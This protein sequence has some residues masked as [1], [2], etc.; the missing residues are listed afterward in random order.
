MEEM[1]T[2]YPKYDNY[3]EQDLHDEYNILV[4]KRWKILINYKPE[5]DEYNDCLIEEV[6]KRM[7][8][9]DRLLENKYSETTFTD[10]N[11]GK[12]VTI[13]R[14]GDP[15]TSVLAPELDLIVELPENEKMFAVEDFIRRKHDE[16]FRFDTLCNDKATELIQNIDKTNINITFKPLT[17]R[18]ECGNPQIVLKRDTKGVL[19]YRKQKQQKNLLNK[20]RNW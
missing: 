13:Q 2:M 10:N 12:T 18:N 14:K 1:S 8:Y 7:N 20:L 11:D 19:K 17:S 9:I 6:N 3:N 16:N 4:K 15:S 5:E